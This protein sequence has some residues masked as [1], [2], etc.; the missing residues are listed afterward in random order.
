MDAYPR[1]CRLALELI[2]RLGRP[3]DDLM[4]QQNDLLRIAA[5]KFAQ[6]YQGDNAFML[7]M[8]AVVNER[9]Y[10]LSLGM[11]VAVLKVM[12]RE[13]AAVATA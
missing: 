2:E 12:R 3:L 6:G 1:E 5:Y 4:T 8:R 7:K 11:S 9:P 13:L 10:R